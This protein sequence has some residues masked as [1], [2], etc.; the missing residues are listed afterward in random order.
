MRLFRPRR[1]VAN[2]V[3]SFPL[4]DRLKIYAVTAGNFSQARLPTLHCSTD[5][6]SRRYAAAK[7]CPIVCTSGDSGILLKDSVGLDT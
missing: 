7:I 6:L 2:R 4:G 3:S 5:R 1:R